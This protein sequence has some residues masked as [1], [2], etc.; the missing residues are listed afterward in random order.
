MKKREHILQYGFLIVL[1]IFLLMWAFIQPY[2]ASPDEDMRYQ[3]VKYI[4]NHNALPD[5]RDP[6]IRNLIWGISYGFNPYL[7]LII[8]AL[9]AKVVSFFT[10]E[11]MALV[12]AG[13]IANVVIATGNAYLVMKIGHELFEKE[14]KWLFVSLVSFLPGAL[15]LGTY[16]N[17]DMLAIFSVSGIIYNWVRA[18]KYGWNVKNSTGLAVF[19]AICTLSYYNAYSFILCS[20]LFF[21][22]TALFYGSKK[23]DFKNMWKWGILIA[24]IV[25]CCAGWWFLRNLIIYDGDLLGRETMNK[26]AELYAQP[27]YRPGLIFTPK[28]AG[29]SVWDM[30]FYV[31]GDFRHN[32]MMTVYYSFIGTFGFMDIFMPD[33]IGKIYFVFFFIGIVGVL[34]HFSYVFGC[35]RTN[36]RKKKEMM[37]TGGFRCRIQYER[38]SFKDTNSLIHLM[39]VLASGITVG[40]A[41]WYSYA[42][43]FQAQGRYIMPILIPMMYFVTMGYKLLLERFVKNEKIRRGFYLISSIIVFAAAVY[44][45]AAVLYPAYR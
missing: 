3:V 7:S 36:I 23:W 21:V 14:E 2:N 1:F 31:H 19:I 25:L 28:S 13:R 29:M 41:V 30:L 33:I 26:C 12:M 37:E 38:K 4:I 5:G 20:I 16:L 17:N 43:D 6:E 27:E 42:S 24:V 10:M 35:H 40:L 11:Q 22:I 18:A 32:W 9:F 8:S 45:Y 34:T 44:A 39:M 15:F